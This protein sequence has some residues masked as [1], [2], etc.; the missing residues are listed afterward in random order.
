MR[1]PDV[2]PRPYVQGVAE[3]RSVTRLTVCL[4]VTVSD[5][6]HETVRW[7]VERAAE[8]AAIDAGAEVLRAVVTSDPY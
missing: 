5:A 7:A 4:E 3:T 8:R 6:D 2:T 1:L